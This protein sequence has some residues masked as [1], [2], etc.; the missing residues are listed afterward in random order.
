[1]IALPLV[2]E[3][4]M[5]ESWIRLDRGLR[6]LIEL[7]ITKKAEDTLYTDSWKCTNAHA[8]NQYSIE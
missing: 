5:T 8:V 4:L 7:F 1:M 6:N 2:M 3:W